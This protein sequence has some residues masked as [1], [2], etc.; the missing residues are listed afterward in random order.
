MF[1]CSLYDFAIIV[2]SCAEVLEFLPMP[3]RFIDDNDHASAV[4]LADHVRYALRSVGQEATFRNSVRSI[5]NAGDTI[6][7][8]PKVADN[9]R[10]RRSSLSLARRMFAPWRWR[11]TTELQ[12]YF[13]ATTGG[14]RI[15]Y[16][17]CSVEHEE[18]LRARFDPPAFPVY[19]KVL[20]LL[21]LSTLAF[22]SW[23]RQQTFLFLVFALLISCLLVALV[24][25]VM[26]Q[27]A[28]K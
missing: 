16:T 26:H 14:L 12:R 5:F 15:V 2:P 18:A 9:L 28:G 25:D 27:R 13:A 23:V 1:V 7:V 4:Y 17:P 21:F 8:Q 3:Y 10:S 24:I 6:F 19:Q 20:C 22:S 11:L